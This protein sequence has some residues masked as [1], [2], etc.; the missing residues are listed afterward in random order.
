MPRK[1]QRVVE[2]RECGQSMS[3]LILDRLTPRKRLQGVSETFKQ[4]PGGGGV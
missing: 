4:D 3:V 2:T 1:E